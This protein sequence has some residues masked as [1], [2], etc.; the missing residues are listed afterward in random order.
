MLCAVVGNETCICEQLHGIYIY[1]YMQ[2]IEFKSFTPS[3]T[4]YIFT[5]ICGQYKANLEF[6][7]I[8]TRQ[9]SILLLS[10][11]LAPYDKG[12]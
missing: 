5:S 7:S 1:I 12:I 8:N 11:N 2:N 10:S 9:N 6:H 3:I 4:I